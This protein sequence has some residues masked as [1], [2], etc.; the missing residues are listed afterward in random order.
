M[1][2]ERH[3]AAAESFLHEERRLSNDGGLGMLSAEYVTYPI[4]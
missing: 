1:N 4:L 3:I 2:Y